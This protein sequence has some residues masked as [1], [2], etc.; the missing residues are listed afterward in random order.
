M[1]TFLLS[2]F[3]HA[4]VMEES[5]F[6]GGGWPGMEEDGGCDKGRWRHKRKDGIIVDQHHCNY[7]Q[8]FVLARSCQELSWIYCLAILT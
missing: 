6:G 5:M 4:R 3:L 2:P 7:F 8:L 1:N